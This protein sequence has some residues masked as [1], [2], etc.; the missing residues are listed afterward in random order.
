MAAVRPFLVRVQAQAKRF[1]DLPEVTRAIT[2]TELLEDVRTA[3]ASVYEDYAKNISPEAR[4]WRAYWD[5]PS[6][7]EDQRFLALPPSF[8][9]FNE[10]NRWNSDRKIILASRPQVAGT[11]RKFGVVLLPH[12]QRLEFTPL[13]TANEASN[14]WELM[15]ETKPIELHYATAL[16]GSTSTTLKMNSSPTVGEY[17][18]RTDYYCGAVIYILSG[19]GID[20]YN[21]V[22]SFVA[23]TGVATMMDEWGTT[24]DDTSVYEIRPW[25]P[26][27][28]G[29]YDEIIAWRMALKYRRMRADDGEAEREAVREI[30]TLLESSLKVVSDMSTEHAPKFRGPRS[31]RRL[32]HNAWR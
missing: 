32:S 3:H 12:S 1:A 5:T 7:T 19:T 8:R 6:L 9:K 27:A 13:V 21:Q 23:A 10:L 2:A 14:V 15:F 11:D 18:A 22:K 24:P 31:R 20:Q 25:V 26:G 17:I 16:A 29:V 28:A 4:Y 30:K